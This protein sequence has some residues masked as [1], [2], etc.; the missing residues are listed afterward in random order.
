MRT[1]H[2]ALVYA[3]CLLP[4]MIMLAAVALCIGTGETVTTFF[5]A[6]R[7]QHPDLTYWLT[8]LT[9]WG[10]PFLYLVYGTIYARAAKGSVL[11]A[12]NPQEARSRRNFVLAWIIAQ[13]LVAFLLVRIFKITIGSPRPNADGT[14]QPFSF[15]SGHNSLP[16]G[17]TTEIVGSVLPLACAAKRRAGILLSALLAVYAALV[18]FSRIYLG[19]HHASDV[20]FGTLTGAFS[21]LLM[22]TVWTH[23]NRK[24]NDAN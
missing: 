11:A 16:S 13:L 4:M 18:G 17:H 8:I 7:Y 15:N 19:Q 22:H 14:F 2:S 3:L 6:Y 9:D 12:R 21:A 10:N 23:L 20:F 24:N 1:S 5:R